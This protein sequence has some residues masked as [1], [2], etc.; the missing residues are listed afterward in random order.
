MGLVNLTIGGKPFSV[1][2]DDGQEQ[3]LVDL[4]HY[5]ERKMKDLARSG[6]AGNENHMLLLTALMLADEVF[7]LRDNVH[8]L[9][10]ESV[11]VGMHGQ[12]MAEE[13]AM[14]AHSIEALA[15]RIDLIAERIQKA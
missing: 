14:M 5:V 6:A 7:D 1:S 2:C 10:E 12:I 3:R 13:E 8:D 15:Q 11:Q 9:R 4:G